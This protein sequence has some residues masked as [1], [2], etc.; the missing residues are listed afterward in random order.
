MEIIFL[1]ASPFFFFSF[2]NSSTRFGA[3][4]RVSNSGTAII[5]NVIICSRYNIL[6]PAGGFSTDRKYYK[7]VNTVWLH[8]NIGWTTRGGERGDK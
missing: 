4:V 1:Y 6:R 2:I 8:H 5:I 3:V 7:Q